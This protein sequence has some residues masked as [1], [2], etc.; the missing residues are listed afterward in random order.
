MNSLKF[1]TNLVS[2]EQ[3]S[4]EINKI[5]SK[6]SYRTTDISVPNIKGNKATNIA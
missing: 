5:N 4:D 6:K 1:S 2:L 3:T